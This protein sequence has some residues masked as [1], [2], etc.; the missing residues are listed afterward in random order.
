MEKKIQQ[1]AKLDC[2]EKKLFQLLFGLKIQKRSTVSSVQCPFRLYDED[3]TVE[4]GKTNERETLLTFQVESL[5]VQDVP[6]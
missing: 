1:Q 6:K 2:W 4:L 3:I 5:F